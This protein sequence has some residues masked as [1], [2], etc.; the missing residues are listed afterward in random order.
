[1]KKTKLYPLDLFRLHQDEAAAFISRFKTGY[2]ALKLD[3][4]G[5]PDFNLI[6]KKNAGSVAYLYF[7]RQPNTGTSRE[8]SH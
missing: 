5:E 1:M 4:A 3:S 8:Q 6:L 2:A 7:S